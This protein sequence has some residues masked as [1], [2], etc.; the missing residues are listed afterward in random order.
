MLIPSPAHA[1][2][3][4]SGG[5]YWPVGTENFHG[6]DGYW[7]Y[8]ASNH[9]W[10]MAQDMPA[11]VG[12]KVYA[13]GKGTVLESG[14]DHGYG[15]VLVVRHKTGDGKYFKAVYGHI[16]RS[17]HTAVGAKVTAGQVIGHVNNAAHVHFGIHPGR[18]YPPDNNPY[19]GHTYIESKT[20]GWVDPIKY[21][22][23]NP[24][25]IV[26][27]APGLPVVAT[28]ETN[29][30]ASV[31][32]VADGIAYWKTGGDLEKTYGRA[33][34]GGDTTVMPADATLPALDETRFS[35]TVADTSFTL[36]DRL[37][38]VTVASSSSSPSWK[39]AVTLSGKLT[40]AAGAVFTGASVVIETSTDGESWSRLSTAWTGL[41]GSYSVTFTPTRRVGIRARFQPPSTYLPAAS[42]VATVAPKPAVA[43]PV[44]PKSAGE[45]HRFTVLGAVT[46]HH[47]AGPSA[48]VLRVQHKSAGEWS[49]DS[50]ATTTYRDSG[51]SSVYRGSLT[52]PSGTYRLRAEVPSDSRHAATHSGWT[53]F[54]L[55]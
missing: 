50:T 1:A 22:R 48:I 8:R 38:R 2:T 6:W 15:G 10:H 14:A 49:D 36:A 21:L 40:N 29:G 39:H 19:R 44:V 4:G 34:A 13:V 35:A 25:V 51:S 17:S 27:V 33:L 43:A 7:V 3:P 30:R 5:W 18:A 32:G 12:H 37:P 52:L 47:T 55:R 20:Y 26:Y 11:A 28:V 23:A 16:R 41:T 46:P 54:A 45:D 53:A 24:R 9:S 42:A 31:L